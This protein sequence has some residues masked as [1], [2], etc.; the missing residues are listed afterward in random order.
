MREIIDYGP[1]YVVAINCPADGIDLLRKTTLFD[2]NDAVT[3]ETVNTLPTARQAKKFCR[4]YIANPKGTVQKIR[5][6]SDD[7]VTHHRALWAVAL[8]GNYLSMMLLSQTSTSPIPHQN[9]IK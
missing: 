3:H 9:A 4:R 2:I 5:M 1:C 8:L 6:L 7:P